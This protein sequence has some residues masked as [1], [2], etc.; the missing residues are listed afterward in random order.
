LLAGLA[1]FKRGYIWRVGSGENINI[2]T[3]PWI[4]ASPN[5]K[6]IS[7]RPDISYSKVIQ[8]I[9]PVSGAW[10][11]A[12]LSS[13]FLPVD[14]NRIL[15]IPLNSN[16]FD[17]FISWKFTKHGRFT[18]RSAYHLQW[19]FQFGPRASRLALPGSSVNNP[20]WKI[21]WKMELPSKIKIFV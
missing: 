1:T 12:T 4:P 2:Y 9:D 16:G 21:L 5:G 7:P 8:L 10:N 19:R 6:I 14:V 18:V 11:E 13:L 17:D 3:D 20:V 15:Q